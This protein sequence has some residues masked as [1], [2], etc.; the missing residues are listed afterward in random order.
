MQVIE[1]FCPSWTLAFL[2][3]P[4]F[5][6]G[7]LRDFSAREPK[8][9]TILDGVVTSD[10]NYSGTMSVLLNDKMIFM[11]NKPSPTNQE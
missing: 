5:R 3:E 10:F 11:V 8:S 4:H 2:G 6:I 9:R 7:L 1:A